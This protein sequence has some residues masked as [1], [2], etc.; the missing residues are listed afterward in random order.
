MYQVVKEIVLCWITTLIGSVV[1]VYCIML[2]FPEDY[3]YVF[4]ESSVA[5]Y[6]WDIFIHNLRIY[7]IFLIPFVGIG[8]ALFSLVIINGYIA[9]SIVSFGLSFSL[10]KLYHYPIECLAFIIPL[11][12]I[13]KKHSLSRRMCIIGLFLGILVLL[14]SAFLEIQLAS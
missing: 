5:K 10:S 14:I 1:L 13:N 9:S 2:M 3:L 11:V 6:W 4:D 7:L 8:Y 12:L